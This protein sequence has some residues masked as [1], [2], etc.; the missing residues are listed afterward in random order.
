MQLGQLGRREFIKLVGGA[1][2]AWP[3]AAVAQAPGRVWKI[4]VL[5]NGPGR[6]SRD[7]GT[8][9]TTSAT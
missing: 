5:A 2:V 4:G 8:G 9:S 7:Y 6:R 1:A 3:A